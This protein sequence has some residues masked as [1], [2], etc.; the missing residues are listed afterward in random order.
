LS[1]LHFRF[2]LFVLILTNNHLDT[3][4]C[5]MKRLLNIVYSAS[6][7]K[8]SFVDN[9]EWRNVMNISNCSSHNWIMK[10]EILSLF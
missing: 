5:W 10:F 3:N 7:E 9:V 6:D 1:V 4:D 8:Q 2:Q